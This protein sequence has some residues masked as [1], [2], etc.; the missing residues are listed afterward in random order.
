MGQ[1]LAS[2]RKVSLEGIT[3][4]AIFMSTALLSLRT[5]T[6]E[7]LIPYAPYFMLALQLTFAITALGHVRLRLSKEYQPVLAT[8]LL[9][10]FLFML[11][12]ST[13]YWSSYPDLVAQRSLLVFVPLLLV[14]LLS[15]S[16]PNPKATFTLVSRGLVAFASSLSVIGLLLYFLGTQVVLEGVRVQTLSLGPVALSQALY[17]VPPFLRISSLTGNP[18]TLAMWIFVGTVLTIY[19]LHNRQLGRL[20]GMLL[21]GLQFTALLFTFSRTGIIATIIG[22]GFYSLWSGGSVSESLKRLFWGVLVVILGIAVF[23]ARDTTSV[24]SSA[25]DLNMRDDIWASLISSF[26]EKPITGVGFG[27]SNEAVLL[28]SGIDRA[29]HNAHLQILVETGLPGYLLF[30]ATCLLVLMTAW[31]RM[32]KAW[33]S[34]QVTPLAAVSAILVSLLVNQLAEGSILRYDF[35]TFFWGY[36]LVAGSH[37]G[38]MGG[39]S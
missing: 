28:P 4:F 36:L 14:V 18:N 2:K 19:L 31:R 24:E 33:S 23:T 7:E 29:G 9:L 11:S 32:A 12:F 6:G 1:S 5:P 34:R 13:A 30:L 15:W 37:P 21:L 26:L 38:M 35:H 17:G 27:V 20:I 8:F 10:G 3:L 22:V 39:K 25:F 16:D